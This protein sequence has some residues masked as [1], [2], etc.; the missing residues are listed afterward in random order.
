MTIAPQPVGFT[1]GLKGC[2]ERLEALRRRGADPEQVLVAVENFIVEILPDRC[3][4][5]NVH[6]PLFR[7]IWTCT[8]SRGLML[9]I[10]P[11]Y[12]AHYNVRTV[13]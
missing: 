11:V 12:I 8:F 9:R 6:T 1:A 2:E 7:C 13:M 5:F 10:T 3:A 4:A